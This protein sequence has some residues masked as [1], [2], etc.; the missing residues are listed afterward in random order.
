MYNKSLLG[1][2]LEFKRQMLCSYL[3]CSVEFH[4]HEVR[5]WFT[6]SHKLA[7]GL[8]GNLMGEKMMRPAT[9]IAKAFLFIAKDHAGLRITPYY[10]YVL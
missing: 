2:D 5:M 8:V 10:V 6:E 3:Q 1:L 4:I 7:P 9:F